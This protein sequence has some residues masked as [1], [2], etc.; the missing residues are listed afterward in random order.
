MSETIRRGIYHYP[1]AYYTPYES[2]LLAF[3]QMKADTSL[4]LHILG[5]GYSYLA[6]TSYN[7]LPQPIS[8]AAI[9]IQSAQRTYLFP[10]ELA[11]KFGNFY[12][13]RPV[14]TIQAELINPTIAPDRYRVGILSPSDTESPIR[15]SQEI[16]TI[17]EY[18]P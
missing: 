6:E 14:R 17:S 9:V 11:Y 8:D 16:V 12:L 1:D 15:F 4:K 7:A 18:K 5:G 3:R 13:N 2:Q 10:A